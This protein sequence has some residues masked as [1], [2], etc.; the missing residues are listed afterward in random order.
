MSHAAFAEGVHGILV[1][2][3]GY[4]DNGLLLHT[5][6]L[7]E[8]SNLGQMDRTLELSSGGMWYV[9]FPHSTSLPSA[10]S[11]KVTLPVGQRL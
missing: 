11:F 3:L 4:R 8:V 7:D 1:S 10:T 5:I 6:S 9:N 2:F